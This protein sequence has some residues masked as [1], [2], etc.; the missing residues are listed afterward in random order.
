MEIA[1]WRHLLALFS[2]QGGLQPGLIVDSGA[3]DGATTELLAKRFPNHTILSVEPI[4]S[5]VKEIHRRN[6]ENVRAVHGGLGK[7]LG[8]ADYP[9]ALDA[10][11]GSIGVQIGQL[12][13]YSRRMR[14]SNRVPYPVYPL[15][16]LVGSARLVF[17]HL[18]VEG[19]E[20]EALL[21]GE[22]SVARWRPVITVETFPHSNAT[23]H[24]ALNAL[25][26]SWGYRCEILDESCGWGDCRNMVCTH[27]V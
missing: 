7:D 16:R 14:G 15:D 27:H 2:L 4:A 8:F 18:D 17:A 13:I 9:A 1:L 19:A 6:L 22:Q 5:N 23:K 11:R 10:K 20:I 25:L 12:A 26:T 21:G 24:T 3:N